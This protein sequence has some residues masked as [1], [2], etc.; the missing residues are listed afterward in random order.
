MSWVYIWTWGF[1]WA[2]EGVGIVGKGSVGNEWEI[3]AGRLQALP[4]DL[5]YL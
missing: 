5:N 3:Y 2:R 4:G 1:I